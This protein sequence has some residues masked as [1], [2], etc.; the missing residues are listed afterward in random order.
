MCAIVGT[1]GCERGLGSF[2]LALTGRAL[3]EL[4][5]LLA[6]T[7]QLLLVGLLV[8]V[9]WGVPRAYRLARRTGRIARNAYRVYVARTA[10]LPPLPVAELPDKPTAMTLADLRFK[11]PANR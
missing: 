11:E 10:T 8:A 7:V 2:L 4:V 6:K 5:K 1:C 3:W 9:I